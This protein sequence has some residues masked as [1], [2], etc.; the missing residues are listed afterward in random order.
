M[1]FGL[2]RGT[3]SEICH[4]KYKMGSDSLGTGMCCPVRRISKAAEAAVCVK[5]TSL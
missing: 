2:V 5:A 4:F 3:V 1:G